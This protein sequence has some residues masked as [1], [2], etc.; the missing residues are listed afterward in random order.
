[1]KKS[2]IASF[3]VCASILV[4]SAFVECSIHGTQQDILFQMGSNSR[5]FSNQDTS[6]FERAKRDMEYGAYANKKNAEY[7]NKRMENNYKA[8]SSGFG[9]ARP[10][11]SDNKK[12]EEK[13]IPKKASEDASSSKGRP[14]SDEAV[15][16]GNTSS[17][18]IAYDAELDEVALDDIQEEAAPSTVDSSD[19]SKGK[20]LRL[21]AVSGLLFLFMALLFKLS[22]K[23]KI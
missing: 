17:G 22:H 18:A 19:G 2:A 5:D 21:L 8:M 15:A 1:M 6:D 23:K 10:K 7:R 13:A 14:H 16:A 3:L 20:V 9:A 4:P 11:A 12:Q